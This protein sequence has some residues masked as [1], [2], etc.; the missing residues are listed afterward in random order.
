MYARTIKITC[1]DKISKDMFVI[2]TETKPDAEGIGNG[3]LMK[4]NVAKLEERRICAECSYNLR[5]S[6]TKLEYL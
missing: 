5:Y 3:S 1:K 2:Y 4:F 6:T